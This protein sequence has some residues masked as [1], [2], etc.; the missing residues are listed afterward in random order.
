MSPGDP[1]TK[2][3]ALSVSVVP[4]HQLLRPIASGAYGQVWLARNRLGA[5]RAVKIVHRVNFA[6]DRPFEREFAGIQAFEPISRSHE[7]LVDLL[8][9][10]RD[11]AAGYF[12]YVM[13]LADALEAPKAQPGNP[14]PCDD[15]TTQLEETQARKS[16]SGAGDDADHQSLPG[17]FAVFDPREADSYLPRTLASELKVRGRLS[18]EECIR[19]GLSLSNALGYL[20]RQ[21]LVHRDVKPS[22]IIFVGG[23]PKLADAGLV[24]SVGEAHSFVGTEGFIPP[25]GPG[26][27]QA[28]I[29]SLGIVLYAMST[30]KSH[31]DFP[32]P[33]ADLTRRPEN[34]RWL[35]LDAVILKACQAEVRRRYQSAEEMHQELLLL[36]RGESVREKR[37]AKRRWGLVKKVGLATLAAT[38]L[39]VGW[40]LV[41]GLHAGHKPDSET[42]RLY[43]LGQWYYTQLTPE[44]HQKALENLTRATERDHNFVEPYAELTFVYLWNL[45]PDMT[46]DQKR[47]ERLKAIAAKATAIDPNSAEA[48]AALSGCRLM[49]RDWPGAESEIVRAIW[50]NPKLAIARDIYCIYLTLLER[51]DE[52][53]RQ[54][55]IA[56]QLEPPDAARV[57]AIV[58]AFPYMGERRYDRA[59]AQ[60]QKVVELDP[61][62]YW[63]RNYLATCYEAQSN[64]VAAIEESKK[65]DLLSNQYPREKVNAAYDALRK[66]YDNFGQEGYYRKCIEL[67]QAD[68]ALPEDQKEFVGESLAGCYARL[69]QKEKAL[70]EI[71]KHFDEPQQWFQIK[72][73]ALHDSLH[74]E[75]RFR[76]LVKRAKLKP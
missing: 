26:T 54:A 34:A 19:I 22:N 61:N 47:L 55:E 75:P 17:G 67:I 21:S 14:A 70:D 35:E 24:T 63:G 2:P 4:E 23:L 45:L 18:C 56:E 69:G 20:H 44:L 32:E 52:A 48:H 27:P 31:Q 37:T 25:E 57:T 68:E 53:H 64:F 6:H 11:D 58:G 9:V 1:A 62:F 65:A 3:A 28:D 76:E 46:T 5:Y 36:Q 51:F 38:L 73:D 30:G 49:E 50:A 33:L 12:Y 39:L 66:A 41:S 60:L 74:D 72:F 42:T 16:G 10:G 59:I 8:Q 29:Y 71:E 15:A 43:K 7:G 13:E 40:Q